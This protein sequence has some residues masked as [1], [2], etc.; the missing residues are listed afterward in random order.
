[1][2]VRARAITSNIVLA[3]QQHLN[4]HTEACQR[5]QPYFPIWF[6]WSIEHELQIQIEKLMR[7]LCDNCMHHEAYS[8]DKFM[9]NL[10]LTLTVSS[11]DT[12]A[13]H[14]SANKSIRD[15]YWHRFAVF[16]L[17][18]NK[19]VVVCMNSW[20]IMFFAIPPCVR[21]CVCSI[22]YVWIHTD[23]RQAPIKLKIK[24]C[25]R[26]TQGRWP[27]NHFSS[28]H[29]SYSLLIFGGMHTTYSYIF[30]LGWPIDAVN[31]N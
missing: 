20:K 6:Q 27:Q 18:N 30:R 4:P 28:I 12:L 25:V 2:C 19:I 23:M 21:M 3:A 7:K 11:S 1:M 16:R 8:R 24:N 26:A 29:R 17:N 13:M 5:W 10:R 22:K 31:S 9:L 14:V 15:C